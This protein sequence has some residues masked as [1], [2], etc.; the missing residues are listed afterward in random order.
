MTLEE[1]GSDVFHAAIEMSLVPIVLADPHQGDCP[2]VFANGAFSELTG[3]DRTEI[4]GRNCRFLQG[5]A[6]DRAVVTQIRKAISERWHIHVELV[7]YRKDGS[8]FW[9]ALFLNPVFDRGGR[10]VYLF[11]TQLDV[12]RRRALEDVLQKSNDLLSV[13]Q[14][15]VAAA[16]A[17]PVSAVQAEHLQ[18]AECAMRETARHQ[19]ALLPERPGG[20]K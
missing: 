4:V 1:N 16:V 14:S 9:N 19:I 3:Y 5:P 6:T 7:N 10:L 20:K 12:T 13:I 2:I 8:T 15:S 18:R 17:L 11:G